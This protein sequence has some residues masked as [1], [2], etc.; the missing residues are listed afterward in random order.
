MHKFFRPKHNRQLRRRLERLLERYQEESVK[1]PLRA[2]LPFLCTAG[3]VLTAAVTATSCTFCYQVESQ[4]RS[5]A[6]F[7]DE[8]IYDT[9][10]TQAQDRASDR[11]SVV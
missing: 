5:L 8:A 2:S 10:L 4:G 11:K 9:A 7:Q 1:H 3:L 6:F